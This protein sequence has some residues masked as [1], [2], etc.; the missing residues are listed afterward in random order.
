MTDNS[1]PAFPLK[2]PLSND[3]LGMSIRDYFAAKV[4]PEFLELCETYAT[5]ATEAYAVADAMLK[6]RE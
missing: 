4:I 6:A 3:S 1:Q 2:E 5:A